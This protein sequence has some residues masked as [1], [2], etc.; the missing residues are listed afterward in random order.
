MSSDIT[1]LPLSLRKGFDTP[2]VVYEEFTGQPYSGYYAH[3][4]STLVI[5]DSD[6]ADSTIAHEYVHFLQYRKLDQGL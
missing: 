5:V 1:W 2:K 4:S 6:R 3:G